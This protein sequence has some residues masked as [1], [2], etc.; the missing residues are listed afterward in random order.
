MD[1]FT[2]A[3]R[4][5]R[6]LRQSPTVTLAA[7][8]CIALGIGSSSAIF[9]AVN[10][11]LLRPLPFR[12]PGSLVTVYRTTPHFDDGPF[13]PANFVDL[14]ASASQLEGLVAVATSTA[15][16]EGPDGGVRVSA[17]RASDGLFPLF[18]VRL[19]GR[20]LRQGDASP[21]Q[22][23]PAALPRFEHWQRRAAARPGGRLHRRPRRRVVHRGRRP[24]RAPPSPS[25]AGSSAPTWI[26]RFGP[27]EA[28]RRR[29]NYLN[30]MG[31]IRPG[32]SLTVA[33]DQLLSRDEQAGRGPVRASRQ[34]LQLAP[35]VAE[36]GQADAHP[37][38]DAAHGAVGLLL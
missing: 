4:A 3:R 37:A 12:D 36:S 19:L 23:P 7:L 9:S 34:S 17:F 32:S 6:S 13:S 15:L 2:T 30:V 26:L 28:S 1:W 38:A 5:T 10:A 18:G 22:Q 29:S 24:R 21:D 20:V 25:A 31:R 33:N 8:A 27:D 16:L 35:L 11:V 14:Q